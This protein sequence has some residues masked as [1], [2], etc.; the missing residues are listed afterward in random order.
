MPLLALPVPPVSVRFAEPGRYGRVDLAQK[1]RELA[2]ETVER[3][4]GH[5]VRSAWAARTG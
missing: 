1:R 3:F 4:P 2:R 5:G